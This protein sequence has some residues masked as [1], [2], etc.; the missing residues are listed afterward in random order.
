MTLSPIENR[1]ELDKKWIKTLFYDIL[2]NLGTMSN[3]D[4]D[5]FVGNNTLIDPEV[6]QLWLTGYTGI[7]LL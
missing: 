5:I 1:I 4:V 7:I 6:Y 2:Q 3:C